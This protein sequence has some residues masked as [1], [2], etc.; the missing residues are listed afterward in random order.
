MIGRTR[1]ETAATGVQIQLGNSSADDAIPPPAQDN[2]RR[3]QRAQPISDRVDGSLQPTGGAGNHADSELPSA[4]DNQPEGLGPSQTSINRRRSRDADGGSSWHRPGSAPDSVIGGDL[5]QDATAS[6]PVES[7][8]PAAVDPGA[9][10]RDRQPARADDV[11][12]SNPLPLSLPAGARTDDQPAT[13]VSSTRTKSA[14][15]ARIVNDAEPPA[16][17]PAS[18]GSMTLG[19]D[20]TGGQ[21]SAA[22][23]L[24]AMPSLA[25]MG[26]SPAVTSVSEVDSLGLGG[27]PTLPESPPPAAPE[28]PPPATGELAQSGSAAP[29][30]PATDSS[31]V[32]VLPTPIG[33]SGVSTGT[34]PSAS[35]NPFALVAAL[36]PVPAQAKIGPPLISPSARQNPSSV[37]HVEASATEAAADPNGPGDSAP[38]PKTW[39]DLVRT[40]PARSAA[41]TKAATIPAGRPVSLLTRRSHQAAPVVAST[42]VA[43]ESQFDS[44][45]NQLVDFQLPGL[46]GQP[47]RFRDLD[48]DFVV[49]DFWGTWCKECMQS[50]PQLVALQ[51]KYGPATL[52]VVGIACEQSPLDAK[53]SQVAAVADKLGINYSVL[54]ASLNDNDPVQRD[55]QVRFYPTMVLLDRRGRVLFRGEGGTE[56]NLFRLEKAMKSA[57]RVSATARR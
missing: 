36:P 29:D 28:S 47:V 54:I 30:F 10:T 52:R 57:Q 46:D 7:L 31:G 25:S 26:P 12:E 3:S 2:R 33:A 6:A 14:R 37:G 11:E 5:E 41:A 35:Y 39:G 50:I 15:L 24:M 55:F 13:K 9:Q 8:E 40:G 23:G 20:P 22:M 32:T 4:P 19:N 51:K 56:S 42:T 43:A 21:Q 34:D 53:R 1:A 48:A 27:A 17:A 18:P 49:L 38:L 45:A 44:A 16:E